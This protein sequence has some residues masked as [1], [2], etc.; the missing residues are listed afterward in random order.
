MPRKSRATE[1]RLQNLSKIQKR[2]NKN[3]INHK[4]GKSF[5]H[6]SHSQTSETL[7]PQVAVLDEPDTLDTVDV[8]TMPNDN[9]TDSEGSI[10][11]ILDSGSDVDICEE[12]ELTKFSRMLFDAQKNAMKE[13]AARGKK[14]RTYTGHSRATEYRRKRV[15]TT[16]ANQG[17][18]PVDEFMKRMESK[19]KAEE[20]TQ[21]QY[22]TI[23]ESEKSSDDDMVTT[24]KDPDME[25]L[26]PVNGDR[27]QVTHSPAASEDCCQVDKCPSHTTI[28]K[29]QDKPFLPLRTTHSEVVTQGPV[30]SD[31]RCQVA[32][33]PVASEEDHQAILPVQ[34]LR[35]EEEEDYDTGSEGEDEG[36]TR[37][38]RQDD[39]SR[40]GTYLE[41]APSWHQ[42]S[43]N[44]QDRL[45]SQAKKV[46]T[47]G[48]RR[49]KISGVGF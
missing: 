40:N 25:E 13:E 10:V 8:S 9:D 33:G 22:L 6:P 19:K 43:W 47:W 26:A 5:S 1:S 12:S 36:T 42:V 34:S 29:L 24:F 27:C 46:P 28:C 44:P 35:E 11:E 49:L 30:A 48:P 39:A 45:V 15:Q 41:A 31:D 32:R 4:S 7:L 17:F 23:E 38:D 20:L 3:N 21:R 14:R 37:E 2:N 16:H 18:L